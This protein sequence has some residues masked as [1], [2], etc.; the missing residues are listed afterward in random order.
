M[1][2]FRQQIEE[3]KRKTEAQFA[4]FSKSEGELQKV[5]DDVLNRIREQHKA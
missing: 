1:I 3:L 5:S 4:T 2:S